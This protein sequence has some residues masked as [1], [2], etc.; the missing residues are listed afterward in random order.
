M[1]AGFKEFGQRFDSGMQGL[2]GPVSPGLD[3]GVSD[4]IARQSM[5]N[6]GLGILGGAGRG[7]PA[8]GKYGHILQ[9]RDYAQKQ[10]MS[11]LEEQRRQEAMQREAERF[12]YTQERDT[13][14]DTYRD[15]DDMRSDRAADL[16]EEQYYYGLT[17]DEVRDRERKRDLDFQEREFEYRQKRDAADRAARQANA[18]AMSRGT[19]GITRISPDKLRD[20]TE[21]MIREAGWVKNPTGPG[22]TRL[23]PD[24]G[25]PSSEPPGG[26]YAMYEEKARQRLIEFGDIDTAVNR[27]NKRFEKSPY[28]GPTREQIE[29][30]LNAGLTEDEIIA[31]W[32]GYNSSD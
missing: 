5:M 23:T 3:S 13:K 31:K 28:G 1:G 24:D 7:G 10:A 25:P 11:L 19:G 4:Q 12:A 26:V 17:R 8:G 29:Q 20:E 14:M 6:A 2:F 21:T 16:A 22:Y 30:L 9:S 32:D 27:I 18:E 15:A